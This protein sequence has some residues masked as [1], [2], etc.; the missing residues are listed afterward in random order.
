MDRRLYALRQFAFA[1]DN[2]EKYGADFLQERLA[3]YRAVLQ[4]WNG[5]VNSNLALLEIYFG[6]SYREEFDSD[7]G[8]KFVEA[9]ALLEAA[10]R[11]NLALTG[12]I[13]GKISALQ[14]QMYDFNLRLLG[15]LNTDLR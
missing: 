15:V 5:S 9:G 11:D 8:R 3:E 13:R 1:Q 10:F 6:G 14:G 4:D 12:D 2:R 7:L